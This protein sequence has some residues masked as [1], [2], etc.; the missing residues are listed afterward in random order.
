MGGT[1]SSED[2][3]MR[4]AF[5]HGFLYLELEKNVYYPGQTIN[6]NAHLL[7]NKA[8]HNVASLDLKLKGK[9][10]FNFKC[11]NKREDSSTR[12]SYQIFDYQ[13]T[14]CSFFNSSIAIG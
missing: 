13:K 2:L 7:I 14:L 11:N 10:T 8:L 3:P 12:N 1:I 5:S 4:I 6:G 9:E